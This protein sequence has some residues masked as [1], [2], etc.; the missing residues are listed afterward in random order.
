MRILEVITP[1]HFSGAERV[2][3]YLSGELARQ[4]HEV[5]VV[6]K[7]LALLER[8]LAE[9]GVACRAEAISG[10]FNPAVG[11]ILRGM[12]REFRPE[13]VHAHLSTAAW[14]GAWA[15]HKE[16]LRCVA[17]V[18]G[19]TSV[20][21]YRRADLL[22]GPSYGV[23]DYLTNHGVPRARTA[24]VYN[25][26][27]PASFVGL[28]PPEQV[29]AELELPTGVPIIGVVAHLAAK[30]GH[31]VLLEAL[32]RLTPRHPQ[33]HCLCLGRGKLRETLEQQARDL[34]LAERVH[35]LGYRHDALAITQLFDVTVLPSTQK[36]GLGLCLI[37]AGFLGIPA[38][39]SDA[40]GMNE[41]VQN[42]VTG[43]LSPPG[44]AAALAEALDRL[45]AD[46]ALR[47][48]LGEAARKRVME[49]FTLQRQVEETVK[50]F[51]RVIR[52]G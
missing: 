9:R 28:P 40:P 24:V 17:H 42:G 52:S 50:V 2:V 18:H 45:L 21:W 48:R 39:G 20:L 30:K 31:R 25:G 14:W 13:V 32:A 26:L 10:K 6:T 22:V 41:V 46:P 3:A 36:E 35:F 49:I 47:H 19:M 44:D 27:D 5:L 15:A 4:G 8:E 51:E 29:R 43:L 38:A 37:E 34:G 33:V 12:I 23:Q 16:G 7:P 1:S 11:R